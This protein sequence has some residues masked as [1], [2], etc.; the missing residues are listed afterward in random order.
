MVEKENSAEKSQRANF[1]KE[2]KCGK[3]GTRQK[4]ENTWYYVCCKCGR[5]YDYEAECEDAYS[6]GEYN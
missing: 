1:L 6:R 4:V 2:V 5:V 3:C